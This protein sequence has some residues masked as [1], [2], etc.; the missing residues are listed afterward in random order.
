MQSY[1]LA[2]EHIR[3]EFDPEHGRILSCSHAGLGI[4]LVSEQRL[5]E[6][7]RLMVKMPDGITYLHATGQSLA[8]CTIDGNRAVLYWTQVET[9][10][11]KL[12]VAVRQQIELDGHTLT[13][14]LEVR[15]DSDHAIE[16][17]YP[18]CIG[19]M[20]NWGEQDDW[21]LCWSLG[22]MVCK[23]LRR[24][25]SSFARWVIRFRSTPRRRRQP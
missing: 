21:Y 12:A 22:Q 20:A 7:W 24:R 19:G 23:R 15:N 17:I 10:E 3:L 11:G 5:A 14:Q 6:N 2:N 9:P 8:S 25:S 16:E 13:A 1:V 4:E 18:L